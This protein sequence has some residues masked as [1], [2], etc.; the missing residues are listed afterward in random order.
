MSNNDYCEKPA[1]PLNI[2]D[3]EELI[4][5]VA[6]QVSISEDMLR[7]SL[8]SVKNVLYRRNLSYWQILDVATNIKSFEN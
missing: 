7:E 8:Q 1:L 3:E 4:R 6:E 5:I 2:R